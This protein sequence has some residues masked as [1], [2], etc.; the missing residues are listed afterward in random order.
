MFP[1]GSQ[2]IGRARIVITK[3]LPS[4]DN[5]DLE[6]GRFCPDSAEDSWTLP[7]SWYRDPAIFHR[8]REKI[9]YRSWVYQCAANELPN[10]GDYYCGAVADQEIIVIRGDDG[11]LRCFYN[12]CSHRAH[13]LLEG[14]G[15][16]GTIVCPY[17]QWCYH[18]DGSFRTARGKDSLKDWIPENA[19]LKPVRLEEYTGLI[20]VNL[21]PNAIPLIE[22]APKFHDDMLAICPQMTDLYRVKRLEREVKA[23]WKIVIDNN[24]ECY[25]CAVNHP[26]LMQLVDYRSRAVWSD[27]GITFS[28]TIDGDGSVKHAAYM[29][30]AA[31]SGQQSLFGYVWPNTIP[32]FFPGPTSLVLF[33]IIPLEP[34]LTMVRHDFYFKQSQPNAQEQALIDWIDTVL[35]PED[36]VL[37]ENVQRGLHSKGYTQ[38]KFM[39]NHNDCSYSEHHVHFFQRLVHS[40]VKD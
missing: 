22:Q 39:V 17:H 25:H 30:G 11:V 1:S 29:L 4:T 20:F 7:S 31:D 6:S 8:E 35:I 15:N 36:M 21:D 24:H 9:F 13:P 12:V 2:S 27:D 34:E 14:Q 32:L 33:Q 26:E 37:C 19:D 28:H 16:I 18:N 10:A 3:V 38:G 40:A 23:N 5:P